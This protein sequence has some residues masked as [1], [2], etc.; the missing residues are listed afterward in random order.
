MTDEIMVAGIIVGILYIGML[1]LFNR[2]MNKDFETFRDK[3]IYIQI[4]K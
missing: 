4:K 2:K 1:V 3:D